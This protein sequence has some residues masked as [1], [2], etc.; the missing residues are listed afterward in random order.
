MTFFGINITRRL[1]LVDPESGQVLQ[2]NIIEKQLYNILSQQM[3]G[4]F[5]TL[6]TNFNT[7]SKYTNL[8]FICISIITL[9]F[10]NL[11]C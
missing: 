11:I 6:E 3:S 5:L 2:H 1:E 7:L 8:F 10:L 4:D 9:L